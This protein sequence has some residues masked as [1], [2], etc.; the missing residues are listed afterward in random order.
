[1][2]ILELAVGWEPLRLRRGE[3]TVL[4]QG[5]YLR[6]GESAPLRSMVDEF[7]KRCRRIKKVPVLSVAHDLSAK[8][9]V[10][11]DR[12]RLHVPTWAPEAAPLPPEISLYIRR[13]AGR[14]RCVPSL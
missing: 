11:T 9:S 1:M 13:W 5:R 2:A 4:A 10:P 7:A 12:T 14:K 8:Y 6:T 3:Q